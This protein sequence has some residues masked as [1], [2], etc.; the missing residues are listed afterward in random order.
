VEAL[1]EFDVGASFEQIRPLIGMGGDKL[2]PAVAGIDAESERGRAIGER[3]REIFKE[4]YLLGLKPFPRVRE[5]LLR[6]RDAGLKL[7]V[8][9]SAKKEEL[10]QLLALARAD[11]ILESVTSSDDAESSK[12]DPDIVHAALGKLGLAA[13]HTLMLGD[14][15]YDI[16][17]AGKLGIG[18]IAFR[19]GG[20]PDADLKGAV[21][22]YD[23]PADLLAGFDQSPLVSS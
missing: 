16:Q 20:W 17:A 3:R 9:S 23:G 15:P 14:T 22:I 7:A 12:P 4:R 21:R 19:C 11:D 18:T 5:M 6:M 10:H 13:S 8:A 2:L 1:A